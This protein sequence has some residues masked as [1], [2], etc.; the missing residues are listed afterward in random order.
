M[1]KLKDS[2][3]IIDLELFMPSQDTVLVEAGMP[4]RKL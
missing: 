2:T 3:S 1:A 4:G